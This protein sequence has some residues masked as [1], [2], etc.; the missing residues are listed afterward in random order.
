[1][2]NQASVS[3]I[4]ACLTA[5]GVVLI[6]TDTVYGLAVSPRFPDSVKRLFHLKNRPD[7]VNLPIMAADLAALE[8][9]GLALNPRARRLFDSPYVPGPLTLVIGFHDKPLVDW[10][11]GRE[12]VAVRIP[13]DARMLAVLAEAGPLLVTSANRH[14]SPTPE[15]C[16]EI[17]AQLNGKPDLAIDGGNLKTVPSTLVNCRQDPPKIEREGVVPAVDL[18]TYFE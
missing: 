1:M 18:Q 13:D 3:E 9:L 11:A 16:D 6:P 17:L 5:G 15:T 7:T 10:L 12:E 2:S 8:A 14:G 4:A